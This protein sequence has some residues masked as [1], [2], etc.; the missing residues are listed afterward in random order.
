MIAR[1]DGAAAPTTGFLAALLGPL[2]ARATYRRLLFLALGG[3]VGAASFCAVVCAV[4]VGGLSAVTLVGAPVVRLML[5][6][7]RGLA[8]FDV[9][10]SGR[11]LDAEMPRVPVVLPDDCGL[12]ACL[13]D[14]DAWTNVAYLLLRFPAGLAGCVAGL[15]VAGSALFLIALPIV[16]GVGV[17]TLQVGP[18]AVDSQARAW[19][20]VPDGILLLIVTPHVVNWLAGLLGRLPWTMIGR[21][22]YR[23]LRADVLAQ[24]VA[25]VELRGA[26]VYGQ[27]RLYHGPSAD[28]TVRKVYVALTELERAGL[29]RRSTGGRSDSYVLTAA[30]RVAASTRRPT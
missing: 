15:S 21:L 5:R 30:G 11:L 16:E 24:F 25:G 19:L 7:M 10:T 8:A 23:R 14:R 3:L 22:D 1:P 4:V 17:H 26:D 13:G 28:C 27:L 9:D 12:L 18:V 29:L 20:L 6:M 2:V